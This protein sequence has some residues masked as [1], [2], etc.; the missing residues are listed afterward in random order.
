MDYLNYDDGVAL[1]TASIIGLN[2]TY[3]LRNFSVL[4]GLT[5]A[6]MII[7][8]FIETVGINLQ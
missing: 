1:Q 3:S 8:N 4:V 2:A 6:A 7:E 5:C